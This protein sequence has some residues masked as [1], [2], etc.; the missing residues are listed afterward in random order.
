MAMMTCMSQQPSSVSC[1][2][3]SLLTIL[4]FFLAVSSAQTIAATPAANSAPPP[5]PDGQGRTPPLERPPLVAP[6]PFETVFHNMP[7]ISISKLGFRSTDDIAALQSAL[8]AENPADVIDWR[9][10]HERGGVRA[11]PSE[12][13]TYWVELWFSSSASY[14]TRHPVL[15]PSHLENSLYLV[16]SNVGGC[17]LCPRSAAFA[18]AP[19]DQLLHGYFVNA[20]SMAKC[21]KQSSRTDKM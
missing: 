7:I 4:A 15:V 5:G 6:T 19:L 16:V 2:F 18:A 13:V 8:A 3:A 20:Q 11:A 9:I 12:V 10:L 1:R 21:V 17:K 14:V